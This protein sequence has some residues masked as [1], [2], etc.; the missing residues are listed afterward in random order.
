MAGWYAAR[1][2]G[3]KCGITVLHG[4]ELQPAGC[5]YELLIYGLDDKDFFDIPRMYDLSIEEISALARERGAFIS[6]AHPFRHGDRPDPSLYH[7]AEVFNRAESFHDDGMRDDASNNLAADFA[8]KNGLIPTCG[9][10]FHEWRHF[11]GIA[12]RFHGEVRDIHTMISKLFARDFDLM[13][14]DGV[15]RPAK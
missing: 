14:P 13:L 2:S 9:Q 15:I 5:L 6:L 11:K 7:G 4:V 12:T 3:E 8:A 1:E 10:D